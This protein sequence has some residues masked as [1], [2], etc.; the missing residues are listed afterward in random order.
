MMY[1]CDAFFEY[2]GK[3]RWWQSLIHATYVYYHIIYPYEFYH[4]LNPESVAL[5]KKIWDMRENRKPT[6][7]TD[8]LEKYYIISQG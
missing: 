1:K 3:K 5:V 6:K 7:S 4:P 8:W 2:R